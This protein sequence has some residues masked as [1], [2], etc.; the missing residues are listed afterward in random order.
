MGAVGIT[1]AVRRLF[2]A[3]SEQPAALQEC[4]RDNVSYCTI[5]AERCR[6]ARVRLG[7]AH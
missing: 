6:S 4:L 7:A 5:G 3:D 2:P 1:P